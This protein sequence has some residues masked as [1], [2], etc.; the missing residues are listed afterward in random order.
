MS[1][2]YDK[3]YT[4]LAEYVSLFTMTMITVIAIYNKNIS[5]FYILYLFWWDEFLKTF[6]DGLKYFNK[7][8]LLNISSNYFKDVKTRCFFLMI[9]LI[10]IIVFFGLIMN[11]KS[12]DLVINNF[13]VFWFR[14]SL[15]NLSIITFLAREIYLYI[16]EKNQLIVHHVLSRGI[17]TLHLSIILGVFLWFFI[18]QKLNFFNDNS[19][20]VL[21]ILPFLLIKMYFEV[22]EI[23]SNQ[24][25]RLKV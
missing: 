23:K 7:K 1:I 16:N 9:Y 25:T 3:K 18:T 21:S 13:E 5:V 19:A 8:N 17:I 10:F 15:F 4:T 22:Q 6:F 24:N 20:S 11:W 14:N 12:E 2:Q